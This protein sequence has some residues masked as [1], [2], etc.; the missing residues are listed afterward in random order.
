MWS[1]GACA[2][3]QGRHF[4]FLA[5]VEQAVADIRTTNRLADSP[6]C[7]V[8]A[9]NSMDMQLSKILRASGQD[10][11][12]EKRILEINPRH[13]LVVALNSDVQAEAGSGKAEQVAELLFDMA[14]IVEG[15]APRDPATFAKSLTTMMNSSL[16]PSSS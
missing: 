1:H 11:G 15:E 9:E 16:S 5:E 3:A 8:A 4:Q 2:G 13:P 6:A 10:A 7:F 12:P 14:L